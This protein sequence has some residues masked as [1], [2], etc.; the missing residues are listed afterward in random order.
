MKFA[1]AVLVLASSVSAFSPST[2][3]KQGRSTA[4]CSSQMSA[5]VATS[6]EEDLA[7]TLKVIMDHEKRSTTV[8]KDQFLS[9][10]KDVQ[11]MEKKQE[12]K[13][14]DPIDVSIPYD[15]AAKLAYEATDKKMEYALFKEQYEADA[16]SAVM[17][18][19][20]L[21]VPY[22][23]AA[24]QAYMTSNRKMPFT[25]FK[26]QYQ[27]DARSAVMAKNSLSVNYD[28]AAL[29]AYTTEADRSISFDD[30]K[31]KYEQEAIAQVIAKK[32]ARE[33]AA[34]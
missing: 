30:F 15:A 8:S 33:V 21:S 12:E 5:A 24:L 34:N 29:L 27:A 9:Q 31:A 26:E 4:S 3:K 16:R 2:N 7:L 1:T 18:K 13:T 28:S 20:D 6:F 22:D 19:N 14:V 25:H 32:E 11:E 10:M 17:A 23:A